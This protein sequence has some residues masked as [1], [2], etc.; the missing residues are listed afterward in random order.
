MCKRTIFTACLALTLIILAASL[1]RWPMMVYAYKHLDSDLAV[2]GLTLR[3]FVQNGNWRWHYPGTPH[4][5]TLPVLISLPAVALWGE[6]PASLVFAGI[7][8]N[9]LLILAIYLLV[10]RAYGT[11]PAILASLVLAAGGLGQVWLSA[12]VTGGHLLSAAWLAWAWLFWTHLIDTKSLKSW[13]GL[14]LFCAIG[15]WIDSIFLLGIAGL[16]LSSVI[17]S[18]QFR[19]TIP[20]KRRSIQALVFTAFL[21]IGPLISKLGDGVNVYGSQFEITT[22]P[23]ALKEHARILLVECLPRL[24]IGRTLKTG[25][26][27]ISMTHLKP[28]DYLSSNYAL[29]MVLTMMA[30]L[31][32]M[33]WLKLISPLTS[34]KSSKTS[35]DSLPDWVNALWYGLTFTALLTLSAFELNKNIF[36]ADNY[37]YLVPLIPLLG[38]TYGL[39]SSAG[40][41]FRQ[42]RFLLI[43]LTLILAIDVHFWQQVNG[44][45][46]SLQ[47]N[48]DKKLETYT[49]KDVVSLLTDP[50]PGPLPAITDTFEADYWE[51]Y[52]AL[53][54]A[55]RPISMGKPFG[56][57][58]NRFPNESP[59]NPRFVLIT[60]SPASLQ[61]LPLIRAEGAKLFSDKR[62]MVYDRSIRE[63]PTPP[64]IS[65]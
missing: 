27:E 61:M 25:S 38:M 45:Y 56:F 39:L 54:L 15:I 19:S 35:S 64:P 16:G 23:S 14:G 62:I 2:D 6:G 37:R 18:W 48:T 12:R 33:T 51:T 26:P 10:N 60:N 32:I 29:A 57:F 17:I 22:D 28:A 46:P 42:R 7:A 53:Y 3:D 34:K 4:I 9:I 52:R 49:N 5:G 63:S 55:Q 31:F 8:A 65:N 30:V 13:A 41:M 44:F 36:N 11:V 21:P 59:P 50:Q 1:I 40:P 43:L 20:I 47:T 58:P 24:I